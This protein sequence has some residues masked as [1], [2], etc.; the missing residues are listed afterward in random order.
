MI[1]P[2]TAIT[3][4]INYRHLYCIFFEK[5]S[6]VTGQCWTWPLDYA[7]S[8]FVVQN[9]HRVHITQGVHNDQPAKQKKTLVLEVAIETSVS[10]F[11]YTYI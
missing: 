2:V 6:I 10:L 8:D 9:L 3:N 11:L 5:G 4:T 1:L 7:F